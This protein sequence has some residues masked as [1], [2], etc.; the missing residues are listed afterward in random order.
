M[1]KI[2]KL[3][4]VLVESFREIIKDNPDKI[5]Q[6][7]SEDFIHDFITSFLLQQKNS[8]L[9]R[10]L[11]KIKKT[12]PEYYKAIQDW[13][14]RSEVL[15]KQMK[16]TFPKKSKSVGPFDQLASEKWT[17]KSFWRMGGN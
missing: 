13:N 17:K 7:I 4:T 1:S 14:R 16:T 15:L 6:I 12:N 9:E 5:N 2:E 10:E 3:R 11:E 8:S